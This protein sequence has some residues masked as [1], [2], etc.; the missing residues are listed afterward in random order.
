MTV[1]RKVAK[2]Q[3]ALRKRKREKEAKEIRK[4]GLE[5]NKALGEAE[6]A[7]ALAKARE[8][9]REAKAKKARAEAPLKAE[10]KAR[11]LRRKKQAH[12]AVKGIIKTGKSLRKSMK[13]WL[14]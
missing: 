13:K 3:I 5:R 2:V 4:L 14:K 11:T 8:D 12:K 9:A 6:K 10:R 7:M 1:K